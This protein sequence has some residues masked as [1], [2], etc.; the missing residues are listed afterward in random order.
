MSKA[1]NILVICS[2]QHR[3]DGMGCA[4]N[5][6]VDTP[7]LDALAARG[8][9]FSHAYCN[10]PIC[11]PSRASF[12]TGLQIHEIPSW[13]NADPYHGQRRSF[14]HRLQD[15]G[16]HTASVGKLHFRDTKDDVGFDEQII[17]MHVRNG[18][19]TFYSPLRSPIPRIV[20]GRKTLEKAGAG[21]TEYT[22]YDTD[23]AEHA[24]Q[25]ISDYSGKGD[26]KPF[27]LN[28]SFV[29]PH[30]PY[31]A[32]DELFH[33]YMA[34]ELPMPEAEDWFEHRS[35]EGVRKY[36]DTESMLP[37][38]R[39]KAVIAAYYANIEFLDQKVGM[40]L[41]ALRDADLEKETL[42]LYFS[43]HGE[44]L[45]EAGLYG[46]CNMF[47]GSVGVPLVLAGPGVAAESV[48]QTPAQLT[49]IY[50]TVL[51]AVG[52][53]PKPSDTA[54]K[55]ESLIKI[56]SALTTDRWILIQ[57]HCAGAET[58]TFTLT[59]GRLKYVHHLDFPPLLF[60]LVKD[61][62]ERDNLADQ[63]EYA[64]EVERLRTLLHDMVDTTAI[65][66]ACRTSQE[67]R[68]QAQGGYDKIMAKTQTRAYSP[69]PE[70]TPASK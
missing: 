28:V 50:P 40:V 59:N 47:E 12:A 54:R 10:A 56:A 21:E 65:D 23:I 34:K 20:A 62:A 52:A 3:R 7:N 49:D 69:P 58:A 37:R 43:D 51:D 57:N 19:G 55:G 24:V 18:T 33:K 30:P 36:F 46:K 63:P 67:A 2:D 35:L 17:P 44:S 61:A 70:K 22:A 13:D 68:V 27:L 4:G 14:M 31:V 38:E 8:T 25:W 48:C 45:G 53:S 16:L 32:P 60:D 11:V 39:H 1:R 6:L 29:N 42:V 9:R 64:K 41:R 66:Q 5:P 26:R 15:A